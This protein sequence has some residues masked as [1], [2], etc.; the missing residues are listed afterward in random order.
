MHPVLSVIPYPCLNPRPGNFS[1]SKCNTS[2]LIGAAPDAKRSIHERSYWDTIGSRTKWIM[3]GGTNWTSAMR[4][5]T[6]VERSAG[7]AKLGRTTPSAW[8]TNGRS[9]FTTSVTTWIRI[10]NIVSDE[11]LLTVVEWEQTQGRFMI[12]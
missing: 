10:R 5:L 9:I 11:K 4:Y 6:I 2:G 8:M 12:R 1:S 3:I 7:M